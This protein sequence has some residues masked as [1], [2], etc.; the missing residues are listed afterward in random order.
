MDAET[1]IIGEMVNTRCMDRAL[2]EQ[3]KNIN[4]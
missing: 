1:S 2:L 4:A 3:K